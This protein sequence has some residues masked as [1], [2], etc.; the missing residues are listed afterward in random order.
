MPH[1]TNDLKDVGLSRMFN[2]TNMKNPLN[3][4]FQNLVMDERAI[5]ININFKRDIR[6]NETKNEL[7][8]TK[9]LNK[10]IFLKHVVM[11]NESHYLD[12]EYKITTKIF[13]P[14]S[15]DDLRAGGYSIFIDEDKS[16]EK[17]MSHFNIKDNTP[18]FER[19]KKLINIINMIPSIDRFYIYY[20]AYR[21]GIEMPLGFIKM[22]NS[23]FNNRIDALSKYCI[24]YRNIFHLT[25]AASEYRAI[26]DDGFLVHQFRKSFFHQNQDIN[27]DINKIKIVITYL[28][29][30]IYYQILIERA[31]IEMPK[32]IKTLKTKIKYGCPRCRAEAFSVAE[33]IIFEI[34]D[35]LSNLRESIKYHKMKFDQKFDERELCLNNLLLLAEK[36][37]DTI[38]DSAARMNHFFYCYQNILRGLNSDEFRCGNI[39]NIY[40]IIYDGVRGRKIIIDT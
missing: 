24:I 22:S 8:L 32:I 35:C 23:E 11:Q 40:K 20:C 27:S 39:L 37:F 14:F 9:P 15:R 10:C 2:C 19:D 38:G 36:N 1:A 4:I 6:L 33:K 21:E 30:I 5:N 3:S 29:A 7:F 13:I 25:G 28:M 18:E 34:D 17:I 31:N 12:L 26:G 16:Y